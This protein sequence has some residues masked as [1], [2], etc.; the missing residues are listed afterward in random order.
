MPDP[1]DEQI[2][3][4]LE[5]TGCGSRDVAI[6]F[7][8][9]NGG[10]FEE[11][12]GE[13]FNNSDPRRYENSI[14]WD[15]AAF[16]GDREG[17]AQNTNAGAMIPYNDVQ[18]NKPLYGPHLAPSRPP[19]RAAYHNE[20]VSGWDYAH[21]EEAMKRSLMDIS[22]GQESGVINAKGH[23][24]VPDTE[25]HFRVRQQGEPAFLKPLPNHDF[26]PALVTILH[27]TPQ[28]R[29]ELLFE[30]HPSND[31][32]YSEHWWEGDS[33]STARVRDLSVYQEDLHDA[34]DEDAIKDTQRLMGF[35]DET[36][37][38]YGSVVSLVKCLRHDPTYTAPWSDEPLYAEV[39]ADWD[40]LL[41]K[42]HKS[43]DRSL[44][45]SCV[46][47]SDPRV[48]EAEGVLKVHF[49]ADV[50]HGLE[51]ED[52]TL[53][54]AIND[55]IWGSPVISSAV[56]D[57]W[58]TRVAPVV[59]MRVQQPWQTHGAPKK[60]AIPK[61]FYADR[62]LERNANI[63]QEVAK[64]MKSHLEALKVVD[65][66]LHKL[67]R[68]VPALAWTP[69]TSVPAIDAPKLM[70]TV[71]HFL[72]GEGK[73]AD[74]QLMSVDVNDGDEV[75]SEVDP[76]I[77]QL[78]AIHARIEHRVKALNEEKEAART[79]LR[80]LSLTLTDP[81]N[82]TG[83][84]PK[85]AYELCGVATMRLNQPAITYLPVRS[86]EDDVDKG[87]QPQWWKMSYETVGTTA[88]V[89]KYKVTEAIVLEAA[90][91]CAADTLLV[92][93][94]AELLNLEVLPAGLPDALQ[95]FVKQD[96]EVFSAELQQA[97]ASEQ[98]ERNQMSELPP[99]GA[100]GAGLEH[101]RGRRMSNSSITV[102][103]GDSPRDESM[104]SGFHVFRVDGY[105]DGSERMMG[106]E[107][108]MQTFSREGAPTGDSAPENSTGAEMKEIRQGPSLIATSLQERPDG[109]VKSPGD[110][111]VD[112]DK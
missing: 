32:G 3:T 24:F 91:S 106:A 45:T 39:L 51:G 6:S 99:Y 9:G 110:G 86:D 21:E 76:I 1:T 105:D 75:D 44:F 111:D 5:F 79:A 60:V 18:E 50:K 57:D 101:D 73:A 42:V 83:P 112:M 4:F 48:E 12:V 100:Q 69:M 13:Y 46:R 64:E 68:Y 90:G 85:S 15:D 96:N 28:V 20:N 55:A 89:S 8:K 77:A 109:G 58:A 97:A 49:N 67:V 88:R 17:G 98:G 61:T 80:E 30:Q 25:A 95:S 52:A 11:A 31:Y 66:K 37:R 59:V 38:S 62:Y 74:D 63:M 40:R 87:R 34:D 23:E 33:I 36:Q 29:R 92:Y 47:T 7:I 19:S 71:I 108:E 27:A 43:N 26:L 14:T 81:D 78:Q 107:E 102:L 104:G 65:Q 35:L 84:V 103:G 70:E 41:T 72:K 16:A 93:V 56:R 2:N 22:G 53:Y 54:D 82:Q 10:K 94:S